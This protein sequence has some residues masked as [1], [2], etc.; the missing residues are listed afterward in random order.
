MRLA[1]TYPALVKA[2]L[3]RRPWRATNGE[4]GARRRTNTTAP[5]A[6][7]EGEKKVHVAAHA[8]S[9]GGSM[10]DEVVDDDDPTLALDTDVAIL[11]NVLSG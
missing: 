11:S 9:S 5:S 3:A 1:R 6:C 8:T 10:R 4:N 7:A 2:M